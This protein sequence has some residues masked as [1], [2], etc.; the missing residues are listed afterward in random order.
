MEESI[1]IT[2]KEFLGIDEDDEDYDLDVLMH[3]NSVFFILNQLGVGPDNGF[4]IQDSDPVWSDYLPDDTSFEAVKT[5][6]F[7][8]VRLAFDTP[9]TSSVVESYNRQIAEYEWR[10]TSA[11]AESS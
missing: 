10:L 7:L 4:S 2:I 5:Y 11:A 1:L 9:L 8:K 6:M 3:I